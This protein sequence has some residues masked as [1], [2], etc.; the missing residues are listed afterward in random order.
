LS[1]EWSNSP[2]VLTNARKT[3]CFPDVTTFN[4]VATSYG[5]NALALMGS[6]IDT[7]SNY[8]QLTTH[9]T[10][11]TTEFTLYSLL[12]RT[13]GGKITPLLRTFGTI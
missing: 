1:G 13:A 12:Y 6:R 5:P 10:L 4:H 11:G 8:F 2:A 3:G 9:V 7:K